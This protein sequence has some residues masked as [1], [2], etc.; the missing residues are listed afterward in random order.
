MSDLPWL[1]SYPDFVPE[2]TS[3]NYS[4]IVEIFEESVKKFGPKTAYKNMDVEISYNDVAEHVDALVWYI[5]NKTNLKK[6]DKIALQMPNLLQYPIAI[7]ACLKAGLV[8]VNTNPLYTSDEMLHQY[9][10]SGAKAIIILENFAVN[11]EAILSKT[12]I[13]TVI[14]TTI[15]D[16]LGGLKGAIVNLVV[17]KVKK[18]YPNIIYQMLFLL[19]TF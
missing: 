19:K 14:T 7:F 12:K 5:Q 6:G 4:S 9:N 8:I 11:L 15:G 10:D 16:M 18:W 3:I 2:T 13:E 17:R 1:K